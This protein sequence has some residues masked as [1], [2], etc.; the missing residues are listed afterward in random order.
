MRNM[1]TETNKVDMVYAT[2]KELVINNHFRPGA[3]MP[4]GALSD[5][6]RVSVTPVREAL[7][8]LQ[9]EALIVAI[10][11]RG[12]FPR[13]VELRE[14]RALYDLAF[15]VLSHSLEQL[16]SGPRSV[17]VELDAFLQ[18][19]PPRHETGDAAVSTWVSFIEQ[20]CLHLARL[21]DNPEITKTIMS[22]NDR[23]HYLRVIDLESRLARQTI[24]DAM[25][26][27]AEALKRRDSKAAIANLRQQRDAKVA[28]L[29]ELVKECLARSFMTRME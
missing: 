4:I 1:S 9:T 17:F 18:I 7:N 25:L 15:V 5:R 8:R 11:Y 28:R 14:A 20:L 26:D 2:L 21:S 13:T 12:F 6:L 24:I 29:P 10:P 23:S 3:P 27:L 16:E 19:C 22:F